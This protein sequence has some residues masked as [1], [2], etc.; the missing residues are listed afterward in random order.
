[1]RIRIAGAVTASMCAATSFIWMAGAFG[2]TTTPPSITLPAT[3]PVCSGESVGQE[4]CI[5][6][7]PASSLNKVDVFFLLDDTGSF[8][9]VAP[10]VGRLFD[11]L[12]GDME[13]ALPGIE[14]GFGVG[15]FEDY[16]GRGLTFGGG[17][18]RGRPFILNQPIVT[19]AD[20]GGEDGLASRVSDAL[21]LTAP[22]NGGDTPESAIEGLYQ[23][24][25]GLG[26]DGNDD[27]STTGSENTQPAGS[28]EAQ[29]QPDAS[30]DVPAFSTLVPTVDHSGSIGGAGFRPDALRLVIL[31]TDACT[32]TAFEPQLGI[33]TELTGTAGVTA[34]VADF[35]CLDNQRFGFVAD[36]T[37]LG[38]NKVENA[39]VPKGGATLPTT[40]AALNAGGIRVLGLF[41]QSEGAISVLAEPAGPSDDPSVFL[42][43]LARLTG[44][45]DAM[46]NPLVF[47]TATEGTPLKDAIVDAVVA[48]TTPRTVDVVLEASG[49]VP[50][51]LD[52]SSAPPVVSDVP[53]GGTACFQVTFLGT[54]I[55]SGTFALD[56]KDEA[57][58]ALLG[59]V[60]V[61]VECAP[62]TTTTPTTTPTTTTTTTTTPT[63]TTTTSTTIPPRCGDGNV[64]AA[65]GE[66]CDAGAANGAPA[67]CCD[68]SCHVAS[69]ETVC[70]T[71]SAACDA[72]AVCDGASPVCPA[73]LPKGDGAL[74]DDGDPATGMSACVAN[75]CQGV[76]LTL[77]VDPEIEAP[78]NP[79]RA[80]I[81]VLIELPGNA[82]TGPTVVQLQSFLGCGDLPALGDCTTKSCRNLQQ[83]LAGLCG[84]PQGA[85]TFAT[86][87]QAPAGLVP[88]TSRVSRKFKASRR[89]QVLVKLRLNKLGRAL[90]ARSTA[91]PLQTQA[92]VQ[93]RRGSTLSALFRTLLSRR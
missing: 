86:R 22:A 45:V 24:A 23:V 26:F 2:Q 13:T 11:S 38:S 36:S 57:S 51:G 89:G 46:G 92:Q 34:P 43:A 14:F 82:E 55:P 12:V 52:V 88:V 76:Q 71:A 19:A 35:A 63:T 80:T 69:A 47:N 41:S 61:S 68:A 8:A 17:D 79:N 44:A 10:E 7:P 84:A 85:V 73:N 48:A 93:E 9:T 29:Q 83:Q 53:A 60:P 58:G 72:D 70:R 75:V 90:F 16:G 18:A 37:E 32:V 28:L 65:L 49:T 59:S 91:L 15:R 31:A 62:T 87:P 42:S 25:T 77:S 50:A 81:P 3:S 40:V 21:A 20:A 54:G 56:F 27:G 67:S 39:V 1:V 74:C 78:A 66:Q 30:G 64:D 6:F 33:P 4:A 5:E